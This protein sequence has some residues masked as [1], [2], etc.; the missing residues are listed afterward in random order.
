MSRQNV[1]VAWAVA[2]AAGLVCILVFNAESAHATAGGWGVGTLSAVKTDNLTAQEA[3]GP[4]YQN[5][6]CS[7]QTAYKKAIITGGW[8]SYIGDGSWQA[9]VSPAADGQFLDSGF[10]SYGA[11]STSFLA[12]DSI[13][14]TIADSFHVLHAPYSN[15]LA[16]VSNVDRSLHIVD[17]YRTVFVRPTYDWAGNLYYISDGNTGYVLKDE[18]SKPISVGSGRIAFSGNAQWMIVEVN[19]RSYVRINL[20]SGQHE[21]LPFAPYV[22]DMY[23]MAAAISNDGR[24]V[25]VYKHY[26]GLYVYDLA[27]CQADKGW[28]VSRDCQFTRYP[29]S[30]LKSMFGYVRN[31]SMRGMRFESNYR[32]SAVVAADLGN[33]SW[34]YSK[35]RLSVPGVEIPQTYMAMGDS[36]SSGEGAGNYTEATNFFADAGNYN[37]CHQSRQAYPEALGSMLDFAWY[38]TIACSG[39]KL[40]DLIYNSKNPDIDYVSKGASLAIDPDSSM[41]EHA[42]ISA[43]PGYIPQLSI[44]KQ[45][46]PTVSTLTIGGN[47]IG[48]GSIVV[49]CVIQANCYSN[50]DSR[51]A[52]A[53]SI[54]AKIPELARTYSVVRENMSGTNPRL[55]VLGYPKLFNEENICL[56]FMG[57]PERRFAN[58]MVEYLN[59]SI[60]LAA[61]KA[62]VFYVDVSDTFAKSDLG[63]SRLCG[64]TSRAVN[65][66]VVDTKD[67]SLRQP[68]MK[69]LS[70]S[71]HPNYLGHLLIAKS[72]YDQTASMTSAMPS[73]VKMSDNIRPNAELY[74][75]LVGDSKNQLSDSIDREIIPGMTTTQPLTAGAAFSVTLNLVESLSLPAIANLFTVQF[76]SDPVTFDQPLLVSA[77]GQTA[78]GNYTVPA[79]TPPGVHSVHVVYTDV[80]G[81]QHDLQQFV[82][83]VASEDDY[84]GNGIPNSQESC[85]FGKTLGVDEDQDGLNDLCDP[86]IV[87]EESPA[88]NDDASGSSIDDSGVTPKPE[89]DSHSPTPGAQPAIQSLVLGSL[90]ERGRGIGLSSTD[91]Y[92]AVLDIGTVYQGESSGLKTDSSH[93]GLLSTNKSLH[94]KSNIPSEPIAI[95]NNSDKWWP[96]TVGCM[97]AVLAISF[98]LIVTRRRNI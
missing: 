29:Y 80:A 74:T 18:N 92:S 94:K 48:F 44:I 83:V 64:D 45:H 37:L 85:V 49:A 24:Y 5:V 96:W 2:L 43:R 11:K 28:F 67:T 75:K 38:D 10:K 42:R 27:R 46:K 16:M 73:P 52:V 17:D 20:E 13:N 25:A 34:E 7:Y 23:A 40:K 69:Y 36:F 6:P 15:R 21:V 78:T 68:I 81:Q 12:V 86:E 71:F 50:R 89:D 47:D 72:V 97:G 19:S 9:C 14:R 60:R 62:G 84:N 61:M 98:G 3:N 53:D 66:L 58:S 35:W 57:Q 8:N 63:D 79:D 76:H 41:I 31:I 1:C 51:E 30:I 65:G 77:D 26:D 70:T 39:S 59:E 93:E 87:R 88:V 54:A 90:V 91:T 32:L 82:M 4:E 56:N 33:N 95:S 22:Y 55:Y